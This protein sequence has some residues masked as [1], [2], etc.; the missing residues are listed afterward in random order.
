MSL[1]PHLPP[2]LLAA[3]AQLYAPLGLALGPVQPEPE[4]AEYGA[5]RL[6]LGGVRLCFRVAKTTPTKAGQFVTLWKRLGR[7]PIQPLDA[8]D[9]LDCC[10][11]STRSG[12]HFGQFVFSTAA[13]LAHGVLARDGQG[14]KRAL[15][16]YPPWDRTTSRQ[17]A[18]TQAWQ[19]AYFL[20]LSAGQPPDLARARA[21]LGLPLP[22]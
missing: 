9:A 6:V 18:A 15:R 3:H 22:A 17:A 14:G 20:D 11:V 7:G 19:A 8:A 4:S 16:V 1:N 5:C 21:L 12:A 10:V 13:L 2:D